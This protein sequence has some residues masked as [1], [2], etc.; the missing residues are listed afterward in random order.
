VVSVVEALSGLPTTFSVDR[1]TYSGWFIGTGY[2]YALGF[3]PGLF[4]KTEYRFAAYGTDRVSLLAGGRVT[5]DSFDQQKFVHT[6]RSEL[7]QT[8]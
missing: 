8:H 3:F 4:W 6:V 7:G 2:V 1:H 5:A